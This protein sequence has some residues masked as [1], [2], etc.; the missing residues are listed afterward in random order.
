LYEGSNQFRGVDGAF[1]LGDPD[2]PVTVIEFADYLCGFCQIYHETIKE[3]IR[4]FVATGQAK[5]EYRFMPIIDQN[6]S[7]LMSATT[8]CA[9]DQDA[10]WPTYEV[11]YELATDRTLT[12]DFVTTVA[13]RLDL[14]A[15][16]LND[17][18]NELGTRPFQF[19]TDY[20]LATELGVT[21][22]PAIRVRVGDGPEG[23]IMIDNTVYDR[24]G[25]PLEI[26]EQF[27]T[28]GNPEDQMRLV[29]RLLDDR[30]LV[31]T[32]LITGE[33]CSAPC[34]NGIVPGETTWD[35]A[36]AILQGDTELGNVDV[37]E[38]DDGLARRAVWSPLA[39][40]PCCQMVTFNGVT[41]DYVRL[42]LAP[43]VSFGELI[44]VYGEPDYLIGSESTRDQ[45]VFTVFYAEIPM[46]VYVFV[47][48][49]AEGELSDSS[50]ILGVHY[51][52]AE[53]MEGIILSN[54][55][56]AWDGYKSYRDYM[57]NEPDSLP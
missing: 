28:D 6:F 2:A 32:S 52:L 44:E 54:P 8:E 42:L 5:F 57:D 37:Q 15:E 53:D 38:A 27:V 10:F 23:A 33:P 20:V 9:A 43:G 45:A 18:V 41:V 25:V 4:T 39:G 26:L 50:E 11:M 29:N 36:L 46:I 14:D 16:V 31:D 24:G 21:G 1:T 51:M 55:L 22:T 35:D 48:G 17:C 40:D 3:F 13:E 19:E 30:L 56:Y 34:W 7:P 12:A 47:A 49:A